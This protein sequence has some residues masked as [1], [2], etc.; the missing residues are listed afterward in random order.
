MNYW[1]TKWLQVFML[2]KPVMTGASRALSRWQWFAIPVLSISELTRYR[3]E[4]WCSSSPHLE[5][6]SGPSIFLSERYLGLLSRTLRCTELKR[7]VTTV[8][9]RAVAQTVSCRLLT[10]A[11]RVEA[12]VGSCGV[13]GGQRGS[14]A[15]FL[16]LFQFPLPILI[17]PIAPQ[18]S[19]SIIWGWYNRPISGR[20]TN[21]TQSHL[22]SPQETKKA[23]KLNENVAVYVHGL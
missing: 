21:W 18:S 20:R 13:F 16:R 17:T 8:N 11:A 2:T 7:T 3:L 9:W 1:I 5:R 14:G 22:T 10:A 15:G 19:S 6:Y 12:Q 23:V 4:L